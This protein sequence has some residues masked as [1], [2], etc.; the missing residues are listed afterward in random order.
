[1][2]LPIDEAIAR[3]PVVRGRGQRE[4][5]RAENRLLRLEEGRRPRGTGSVMYLTKDR[6]WRG[7]YRW[8]GRIQ[9]VTGRTPEEAEARLEAARGQEPEIAAIIRRDLAWEQ[10][11]ARAEALGDIQLSRLLTEYS[12]AEAHRAEVHRRDWHRRVLTEPRP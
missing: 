6:R 7:T 10:L 9:Y 8:A 3:K 1:M 4:R 5:L 12:E 11:H 2:A